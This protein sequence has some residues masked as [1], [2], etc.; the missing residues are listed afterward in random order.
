MYMYHQLAKQGE[1]Y[2]G[3][4][5]DFAPKMQKEPLKISIHY[6]LQYGRHPYMPARSYSYM[7]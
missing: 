5:G 3:A 6:T 2:T 7:P 4:P 1:K